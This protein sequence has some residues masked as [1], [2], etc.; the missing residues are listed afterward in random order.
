MP[1]RVG[2]ITIFIT[3][4]QMACLRPDA[5][6]TSSQ[7]SPSHCSYLAK[8]KADRMADS[9]FGA[10]EATL[11]EPFEAISDWL[12]SSPEI[13]WLSQLKEASRS[14]FVQQYHL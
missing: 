7:F 3:Y 11:L 12:L 13:D 1:V 4:Y 8:E 14:K 9:F 5:R 10:A 2:R 6:R